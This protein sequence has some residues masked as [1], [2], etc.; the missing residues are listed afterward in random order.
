MGTAHVPCSKSTAVALTLQH[1]AWLQFGLDLMHKNG[2]VLKCH[3]APW[4]DEYY[5]QLG[6]SR[7][8]LDAG[9]NLDSFM[10]R[11]RGVDWTQHRNWGC[12][13]K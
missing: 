9:Y 5:S 2:S 13:A 12:N 10:L 7:A 11:Y 4:E 6:A 8:I 3:S 1:A